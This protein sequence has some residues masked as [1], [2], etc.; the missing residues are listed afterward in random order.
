MICTKIPK[1]E[2]FQREHFL[3][4]SSFSM[5]LAISIKLSLSNHVVHKSHWLYAEVINQLQNVFVC[6]WVSI[7]TANHS[8]LIRM[9]KKVAGRKEA[10]RAMFWMFQIVVSIKVTSFMVRVEKLSVCKVIVLA[11]CWL[12]LSRQ[13]L[14][15]TKFVIESW[16]LIYECSGSCSRLYSEASSRFGR[17]SLTCAY[18]CQ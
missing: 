1:P 7:V 8:K 10:N 5:W 16:R 2:G 9:S 6:V 14:L 12:Q 15:T 4:Y 3:E 13:Q 18:P 17:R 11:V